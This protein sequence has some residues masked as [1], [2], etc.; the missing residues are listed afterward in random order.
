V[1]LDVLLD[2]L[3][4]DARAEA[5]ERRRVAQAEAEAVIARAAAEVDR[6]RGLAMAELCDR[7]RVEVTREAAAT[8]RALTAR[9]LEA[10]AALLERIFAEA[11]ERLRRLP[12]SRWR[13]RLPDL[14]RETSVFLAGS[15]AD[16]ICDAEAGAELGPLIAGMPGLRV[17]IAP[18]AAPGLLGRTRDGRV[19]VDNTWP[20]RLERNR[21]ALAIRLLQLLEGDTGALG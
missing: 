12:F 16:L 19:L 10:R 7:R 1:A 3:E 8:A 2:A 20:A 9:V 4:R 5:G 15:D 13:E 21:E 11:G 18:D 14:A 6:R 17:V